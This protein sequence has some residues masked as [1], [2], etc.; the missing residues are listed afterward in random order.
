M[1]TT[2]AN[3]PP[4]EKLLPILLTSWEAGGNPVGMDD[5]FRL[6]S[7]LQ[8]IP[9]GTS[10][11]QLKTL[12]TPLL[13]Q[14]R[15]QQ[16]DFYRIFDA[17]LHTLLEN[18][19]RAQKAARQK[20][21]SQ[22]PAVQ[23][24]KRKYGG[25]RL[26]TF[27]LFFLVLA[28]GSGVYY[29]YFI[30]A[31][32]YREFVVKPGILDGRE[33]IFCLD[34]EENGKFEKLK[35]TGRH[36]QL[37]SE[38]EEAGKLCINYRVAAVGGDTL[39][40]RIVT[41][42]GG[43][44]K[45]R[46]LFAWALLPYVP[47]AGLPTNAPL[48]VDVSKMKPLAS[49]S[50]TAILVDGRVTPLDTANFQLRD[51][52]AKEK[53]GNY[54]HGVSTSWQFGYGKAH[55]SWTKG[56]IVLFAAVAAWVAGYWLRRR[57]QKY[58]LKYNAEK[59][60]PY[61]WTLRVS[62]WDYVAL[63]QGFQTLLK[64]MRQRI[65]FESRKIDVLK[66]IHSTVKKGGQVMFEYSQRQ[67]LKDYLF[68]VDIHSS[69]N[70]RAR[71]YELIANTLQSTDVP[72]E[73]FSFDG[74]IRMCHNEKF[75][76]GISL[77]MLQHKYA[78]YRLVIFST[79]EQL[80]GDR[81]NYDGNW[82]AAF[83]AWRIKA[84]MTPKPAVEWGETEAQ[85]ARHFR[86]LPAT[87]GGF[88]DLIDSLE[89]IEPKNYLRW[90]DEPEEIAS[91]VFF[92]GK[93]TEQVMHEELSRQFM[94]KKD[95]EDDDRLLRWI[96]ACALPPVLFWEWTL[97]MGHLLSDPG[98]RFL[99]TD[100]LFKI[101]RLSWFVEG[102]MP[103]DVRKALIEMAELRFPF[104]LDT[105]KYEWEHVLKLEENIPPMGSIAWH[106]H[107]IQVILSE[108][109]QDAN[110]RKRRELEQE[111][112]ALLAAGGN[113]HDAMVIHYMEGRKS[114]LDH[115]V[116]ERFRKYVYE[117]QGLFWR[118]RDWV[119]QVPA[120]ASVLLATLLVHYTEPVTTFKFRDNITALAVSPD[121][122]TFVAASGMGNIGICNTTGDWIMGVETPNDRV[123]TTG[124]SWDEKQIVAGSEDGGINIWNRKGGVV[125]SFHAE[126]GKMVTSMTFSPDLKYVLIGFF[127]GYAELRDVTDNVVL[128]RYEGHKSAVSEVVFSPDGKSVLTGSRDRT[129][130]LWTLEG[131]L[132]HTLEGHTDA[133]HAVAFSPDGSKIVTG[134]RD[135]TA[136]LWDREGKLLKT[137]SGHQYDV[138]DVQFSPDGELVLTAGGDYDAK[139]WD[140]GGNCLRTF[141]G[142]R[143]YIRSATFSP[144][145]SRV[146]TGDSN[147][148]VKIFML[149]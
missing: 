13:A 3:M 87:P 137:F 36:V 121:G 144:D 139:L 96:A 70:H 108:L 42:Q 2:P 15:Q 119:W 52:E 60:P 57:R 146:F 101:I 29:K 90:T 77:S 16:E 67:Q 37:L 88:T 41:E 148:E 61:D 12:I 82:P 23:W 71:L 118:L 89:V 34:L 47:S 11:E 142:H 86:L 24:F 54:V 85:L 33:R 111:L 124:F 72:V 78:G 141:S 1:K 49:D 105:V 112:D 134:S 110:R 27:P 147:G 140:L 95:G 46:F 98:E 76:Q 100:N 132:L 30:A 81:L 45:V 102:K 115:V 131:E 64:E 21:W 109:L 136:R 107:R 133:V 122:S 58:S 31:K 149:K 39:E 5:Y 14:D 9:P 38:F 7:L 69:E 103:E 130:K 93:P 4:W 94:E 48:L 143:H 51:V 114:P 138:F 127:A 104:W 75:P 106:G 63:G 26:R 65:A 91:P 80:P 22:L 126:P 25:Y 128:Q 117:P 28:L 44:S 120:V 99:N 74:D 113:Q 50:I 40:Y 6:R 79:G 125:R 20:N 92:K 8:Q 35:F 10:A 145:Q 59:K 84:L 116:S 19:E 43:S 18:E 83:D 56:L 55:F 73:R 62:L 53:E 123:V 68:L 129:A 135:Q 97:Y 32:N 66:T 17:S